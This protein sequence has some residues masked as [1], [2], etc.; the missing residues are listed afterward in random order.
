MHKSNSLFIPVNKKVHLH[1]LTYHGITQGGLWIQTVHNT[2]T[3]P[4]PVLFQ[5]KN[6]P[7]VIH[8][9]FECNAGSNNKF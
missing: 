5:C 8:N 9:Q 7:S 6:F 2:E 4:A 1:S 3:T